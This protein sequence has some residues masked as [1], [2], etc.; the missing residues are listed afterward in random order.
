MFSGKGKGLPI[1]I[2]VML[3][4]IIIYL[5][6]TVEQPL[7]V[8]DKKERH[9]LDIV[10]TERLETTLDGN[11]IRKM[12]LIR[13]IELPDEFVD[14]VESIMFSFE[15]AYQYLGKGKYNITR[16]KNK[17]IIKVEVED[18]ETII[19]NNVEFFENDGLQMIINSNT[20]SSG[21]LTL[22]VGDDYTEGEFK[23][24]LKNNGYSCK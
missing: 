11:E 21:V 9:D 2:T 20:R 6:A 13:T 24:R 3:I 4:V 14:D 16:D 17:V 23:T 18:D 22:R 5:F 15:K 7:V 8:C 19:L 1:V 12:I 10:S